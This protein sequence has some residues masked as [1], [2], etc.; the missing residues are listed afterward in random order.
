[1]LYMNNLCHHY[2]INAL[3][4]AFYTKDVM[5]A[6]KGLDKTPFI[7]SLFNAISFPDLQILLFCLTRITFWK[8]C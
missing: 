1:M 6:L 3:L 7:V 4:R 2:Y 5:K 8:L